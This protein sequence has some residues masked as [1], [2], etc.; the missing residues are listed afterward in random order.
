MHLKLPVLARTS[1]LITKVIKMKDLIFLA[2]CN[3]LC[4]LRLYVTFPQ[5][6]VFHSLP[7]RASAKIFLIF[8]LYTYQGLPECDISDFL[9]DQH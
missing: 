4:K 9:F 3:T 7:F 8:V 5:Q 6:L 2:Y 1:K